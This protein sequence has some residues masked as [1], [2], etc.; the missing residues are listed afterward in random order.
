M[1]ATIDEMN[2]ATAAMASER[3]GPKMSSRTGQQLLPTPSKLMPLFCSPG[4]FSTTVAIPT[5][6]SYIYEPPGS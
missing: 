5:A 2:A 6:I 1:Q 4:W 3:C